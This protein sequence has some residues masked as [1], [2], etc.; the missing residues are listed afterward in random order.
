MKTRFTI[1]DLRNGK[2]AVIND[3]TLLELN[4]VLNEAFPIPCYDF[5][6]G[7][8]FYFADPN[9]HK[10]NFSIYQWGRSNNTTLPTQSV[11]DFLNQEDGK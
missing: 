11:K 8:K 3:G 5:S 4:K 2:C 9:F 1:E 10:N 6:G 7:A